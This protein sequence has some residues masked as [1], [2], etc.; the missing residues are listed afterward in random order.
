MGRFFSDDV[1][2]IRL[3]IA[4]VNN[5]CITFGSIRPELNTE[6]TRLNYIYDRDQHSFELYTGDKVKDIENVIYLVSYI[7]QVVC[8]DG[9][10]IQNL[11]RE[12]KTN[13][14]RSWLYSINTLP[15][16]PKV[17]EKSIQLNTTYTPKKKRVKLIKNV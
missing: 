9:Y 5:T 16:L 7:R 6:K 12:S 11:L 10:R 8:K 2:S 15:T 13:S 3:H 17:A 4:L 14:D 1:L